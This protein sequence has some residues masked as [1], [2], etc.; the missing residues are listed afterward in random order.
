VDYDKFEKF[1]KMA[2]KDLD[3]AKKA[4]NEKEKVV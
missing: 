2:V 3:V 1:K 4:V